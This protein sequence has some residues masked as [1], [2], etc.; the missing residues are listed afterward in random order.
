M[1]SNQGALK[2]PPKRESRKKIPEIDSQQKTQFSLL[3][4]YT[5]IKDLIC[6]FSIDTREL[7]Y[8][9]LMMS[10]PKFVRS[11][12]IST[13]PR[14]LKFSEFLRPLYNFTN[15]TSI[16]IRPINEGIA[17]SNLN[18]IIND[19]EAEKM[20]ALKKGDRNKE[21]AL[22]HQK[23][24]AEN[25]RD[26]IATQFNKLFEVSVLTTLFS[27]SHD[28]LDGLSELLALEMSKNMINIRSAWSEQVNALKS[29]MPVC[30]NT[31]NIHNTFD[32]FGASTLFPFISADIS[33]PTGIPIG[34]N[35][36]SGLPVL[37]DTFNPQFSNFNFLIL[38]KNASGKRV[39]TQLIS[40]RS[41]VL[42]GIQSAALDA[43]GRFSKIADSLNGINIKIGTSKPK[44][45]INPFELETETVKDEITGREKIVLNLQSKMNDVTNILSTMA[46]GSVKSQF[47]N[48][49]TRKLILS[50]VVE[51]YNSAGI[52]E[53]PDSLYSSQ[54]A[55]LIGSKI[56]RDKKS[57]PTLGSWYKRLCEKANSDTNPDYKYHYE[58]LIRY[59]KDFINEAGGK[60]SYYDG[61]STLD[62]SHDTPFVNFDLSG[63]DPTFEK[64]LAQQIL[65]SWLW[66][67]Y[68]KSNSQERYKADKK[69]IIIDELWL[70]L[71]YPEAV[72]C[73][74]VIAQRSAKRNISF[75]VIS[76]RFDEF[77]KNK[78]LVK[79][80]TGASIKL[81][82][83]H[84]DSDIE[85]LKETFKLADGERDFLSNCLKGEGILK[86]GS[87]TAQIY[88]APTGH[89]IELIEAAFGN[90]ALMGS[91][92]D[93]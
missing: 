45:I 82:M 93:E 50:I 11:F 41:S 32:T 84:D 1:G 34:V 16:Y 43:D 36:K 30:K 57:L 47:V 76:Q 78:K 88:I 8:M 7:N 64:P 62:L 56:T 77:I 33:H 12:F 52:T 61:Q 49:T 10:T 74:D 28:H 31:M 55:N 91:N 44:I 90:F 14:F 60:Y 72:D 58:Y 19:I 75:G 37:M 42:A 35:K 86:I 39:A 73:L 2:K 87:N 38:G 83:Q 81:L 68:C 79:L 85:A 13:V 27:N 9:K 53:N 17:Q 23:L 6:P 69:R 46:R 5:N 4:N 89:E 40:L 24:E 71:P 15:N 54:G 29:N 92:M 67:K 18:A 63:L 48:D 66:E 25:L 80:M 21:H 26:E 3:A 65:L 70:L 51:E 20:E 59:M 22:Q